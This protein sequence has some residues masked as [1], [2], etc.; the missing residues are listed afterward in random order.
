MV[1]GDTT[2]GEMTFGQLD[3]FPPNLFHPQEL[4]KKE[5][6]PSLCQKE[7]TRDLTVC[8]LKAYETV[9]KQK[10]QPCLCDLKANDGSLSYDKNSVV[11][12]HC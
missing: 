1:L 7:A 8:D 10:S 11:H 9:E 4:E 2:S 5:F 6:I 3:R 12:V